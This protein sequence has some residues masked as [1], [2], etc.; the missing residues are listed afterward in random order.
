[1]TSVITITCGPAFVHYQNTLKTSLAG[2][3]YYLL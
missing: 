3:T 2:Q 1:M